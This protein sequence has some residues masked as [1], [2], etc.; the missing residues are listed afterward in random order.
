[1]SGHDGG[2]DGSDRRS[3]RRGDTDAARWHREQPMPLL[4]CG[5][6]LD[7]RYFTARSCIGSVVLRGTNSRITRTQGGRLR[8][9]SARALSMHGSA[10]N[11]MHCSF[12]SSEH[13]RAHCSFAH[14]NVFC[15]D[16]LTLSLVCDQHL[17]N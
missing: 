14:R 3:R 5:L 15:S 9:A 2:D 4:G 10:R 1:M 8:S 11:N 7:Q 6:S 17:Y 16:L 13:Q 12:G